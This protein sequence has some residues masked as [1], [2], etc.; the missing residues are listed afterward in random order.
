MISGINCVRGE[1]FTCRVGIKNDF[2]KFIETIIPYESW[3]FQ[4][5]RGRLVYLFLNDE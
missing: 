4:F 1:L 3:I 2:T 5:M